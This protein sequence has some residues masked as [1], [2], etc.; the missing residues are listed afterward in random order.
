MDSK[1]AIVIPIYK[2]SLSRYEQI[3]LERCF[4]VLR[5]YPII[6]VK[7]YNFDIDVCYSQFSFHKFTSFN[8]DFFKSISGYNRL[9]LSDAFYQSFSEYDF[10]LIY[11]LD[12]FVFDD[13]LQE[14][15][16]RGYDYIG[17]PWLSTYQSPDLIKSVKEN[18]LR[19]YHI[20]RNIRD[21][22]NPDLPSQK[23]FQNTVGNGGFS[24]RRVAKFIDVCRKYREEIDLYNRNDHHT[25]NEDVFFSIELNRLRPVLKIPNYKI[26]SHFALENSP[27][28]GLALNKG[29]LPFGC[30]DWDEY[31]DFWRPYFKDFGYFI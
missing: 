4:T 31:V 2:A 9:M 17:A 18:F 21:K 23:Q 29:K 19:K 22:E 15:C 14:W 3:S 20:I 8:D 24:L 10:I 27:E 26:A 30:H 1:V 25:Y 28:I 12:C 11:Q 13:Q 6:G 7:P 5:N 16:M